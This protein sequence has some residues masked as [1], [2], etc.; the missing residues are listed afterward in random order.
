M[1]EVEEEEEEEEEQGKEMVVELSEV[2]CDA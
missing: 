2:P 1:R